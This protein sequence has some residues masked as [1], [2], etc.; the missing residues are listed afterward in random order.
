MRKVA[1]ESAGS[2]VSQN[3]WSFVKWKPPLSRLTTTTLQSD[4]T[5]NASASAGIEI[6]RLRRAT[7]WPL[8][9]QNAAF[10]GS[11]LVSK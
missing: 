9:R 4:H 5:V 1:P 3:N 8:A 7:D 11:H 10:S 2:A 6:Q